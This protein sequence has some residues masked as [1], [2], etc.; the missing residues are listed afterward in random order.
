MAKLKEATKDQ[1]DGLESTVNVMDHTFS[2]EDYVGLMTRFYRFYRAFEPEIG[3]LDW[4]GTGYDPL[5]RAKLPK[6]ER[7]LDNLG[8]PSAE[9]EELTPFTELPLL[10]NHARAFGSLYVVEGATLGGQLIKRHLEQ[11]LGLTPDNGAA[12]FGGYGAETGP[13]WKRFG[14]SLTEFAEMH[15]SEDEIIANARQTFDSFKACF[16]QPL[17]GPKTKKTSV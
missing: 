5:E 12:F 7:D 16:E 6:L 4:T 17:N 13:M 9:R 1:H 3:R 14:S 2:L 11:H 10:D 15:G 8:V